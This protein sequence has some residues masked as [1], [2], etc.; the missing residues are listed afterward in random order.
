MKE[1]IGRSQI[2]KRVTTFTVNI[3]CFFISLFLRIKRIFMKESIGETDIEFL[4]STDVRL[5]IRSGN[6]GLLI[7]L[8]HQ[9]VG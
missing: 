9:S 8:S 7:Q 4:D 5:F 3:V 1:V 6:S 2:L